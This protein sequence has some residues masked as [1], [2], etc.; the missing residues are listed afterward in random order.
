M[1]AEPSV[2]RA[3]NLPALL[4][5]LHSLEDWAFLHLPS[6]RGVKHEST[7]PRVRRNADAVNTSRFGL[8]PRIC[9]YSAARKV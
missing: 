2:T 3:P 5:S 8:P 1:S 6:N 9:R 7:D 4:S